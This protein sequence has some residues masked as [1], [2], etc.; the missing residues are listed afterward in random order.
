MYGGAEN[1]SDEFLDILTKPMPPM[2][3]LSTQNVTKV[4]DEDVE[5]WYMEEVWKLVGWDILAREGGW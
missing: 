1:A 3:G 2:R 4:K 5:S